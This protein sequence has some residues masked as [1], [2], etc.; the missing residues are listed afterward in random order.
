MG[1]SATGAGKVAG[2]VVAGAILFS[3][4]MPR[5]H[6]GIGGLPRHGKQ[7]KNKRSQ[8]RNHTQKST[9]QHSIR[10]MGTSICIA[11]QEVEEYKEKGKREN[12]GGVLRRRG[13]GAEPLPRKTRFAKPGGV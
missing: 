4:M 8:A 12:G 13:K 3:V 2:C 9:S 1:G 6:S 5:N 11:S 7:Q 10:I